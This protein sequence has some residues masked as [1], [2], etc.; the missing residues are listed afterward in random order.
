MRTMA[1][2]P[3]FVL[4]GRAAEPAL[5][6]AQPAG[7]S[8]LEWQRTIGN[9]AVGE[10]IHADAGTVSSGARTTIIQGEGEE[11]EQEEKKAPSQEPSVV[12]SSRLAG[13]RTG[14]HFA[15]SPAPGVYWGAGTPR[16]AVGA[17]SMVPFASFTPKPV[18][19]GELQGRASERGPRVTGPPVAKNL[20]T[21]FG[22][23]GH[24]T[25]G[26]TWWPAG[27]KAPD[28]ELNATAS[29]GAWTAR[30]T[31]KTAAFEGASNSFFTAAGKHAT[32]DK[33]GGKDVF[34][35]VSAAVSDN[36]KV[37]EQEHC[38]DFTEAYNISLKEADTLLN[39]HIAGKAFGPK[40]TKA[41]AEGLVPAEITA[42]LTHPGLG[43]DKTRWAGIYDT[44]FHK[45]LVRDT[46]NDHTM[47]VG[48]RTVDGAGNVTYEVEKG[49]SRIPGSASTDIIKY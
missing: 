16:A 45:T 44:L 12:V 43:N 17:S 15:A 33:E 23:G 4:Q 25:L 29:G 48:T 47:R 18:S 37:G 31:M 13:L 6:G 21:L 2:K 42:K 24:G 19:W 40:P 30:P 36:F 14:A 27:F 39:A 7:H 46:S 32:G 3:E 34:W 26:F 41:E 35:N 8:I 1:Q 38:D 28:F 9:R 20:A 49:T 22:A 10:L 11:A 5:S